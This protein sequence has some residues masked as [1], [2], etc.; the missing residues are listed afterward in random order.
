MNRT[1]LFFLCL[2]SMILSLLSFNTDVSAAGENIF[3]SPDGTSSDTCEQGDP[4][5]VATAL[6][7]AISGDSLYFELGTYKSSGS[8]ILAINKGIKMYGG[9]SGAPN[10]AL[11]LDPEAYPTIFDGENARRIMNINFNSDAHTILITGFNFLKGYD[12][13]SGGAI[14]I[15]NGNVEITNNH[16]NNNQA[17]SY[18]GAINIESD[19]DVVVKNN[20]FADNSVTHGGGA[21]SISYPTGATS[22]YSIEGNTFTG[23]LADYGTAIHVSSART[24][25]TRNL[26]MDNPGA[27]AVSF[28]LSANAPSSVISNN[29]IIRSETALRFTGSS[30]A[31]QKVW[32][33]TIVGGDFGVDGYQAN[34]EIINNIISNTKT[35]IRNSSGITTGNH[36]LF[37]QNDDD[38]D[39]TYKLLNPITYN[40]PL[41]VNPLNDD[42]HLQDESPARDH[43]VTLEELIVDFDGDARPIGDYYDIG[44]DEVVGTQFLFLPLI[45]R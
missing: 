6:D 19:L 2:I 26:F 1:G 45:L 43:G 34:L 42:Y 30:T 32:N 23:G 10:G 18:G 21:I 27:Y 41:F 25:I 7:K 29:F 22:I 17:A 16:F 5:D 24:V 31:I 12:T 3:V 4:C 14:N 8:S 37:F 20:V 13:V 39:P 9:W 36:N 11:V 38:P 40:D 15:I 44:A 28:S 35:S 33:N